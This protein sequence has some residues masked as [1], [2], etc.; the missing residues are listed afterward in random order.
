MDEILT[1]KNETGMSVICSSVGGGLVD[2]E[3]PDKNGN[4]APVLI[5]PA[6]FDQYFRNDAQFGKPAGRTA[7]RISPKIF[8]IEGET[9]E[10]DKGV[11]EP[12]ALHGGKECISMKTFS[13]EKKHDRNSQSIAF[14]Y[15][16]KDGEGGF[17]G[18]LHITITFTLFNKENRLLIHHEAKTDKPTLCNL[19]CHAYFNL[20]GDCA[21]NILDEDLYIAASR[22]GKVNENTVATEL[23]KADDNFS[24]ITPHEI[25]DHIEEME[26]QTN[27]H[28]YDHPY[29]FDEVKPDKVQASLYDKVSGR[30]LEIKT[31]YE[32]CVLYTCNWPGTFPIQNHNYL[33]KYDGVC[34]EMQHFP[35]TINS[36]FIKEK[37]DVL[38]VKK[39]YDNFIEYKFSIK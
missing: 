14:S 39:K 4:I 35:N 24:F 34:L 31:S 6:K 19:T 15:L 29:M 27:T 9:Y 37:T 32:A 26:V 33:E 7:G 20:S 12:F 38:S 21:R 2:I 3:V 36:D 22:V 25:G 8:T 11:D 18:N 28:G 30:L 16:S 23:V 13:Y 10:I 5:R 17:P 1:M